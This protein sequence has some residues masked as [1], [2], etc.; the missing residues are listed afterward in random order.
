MNTVHHSTTRSAITKALLIWA[1]FMSALILVW[2]GNSDTQDT[3]NAN[4][5]QQQWTVVSS[6]TD[7][8]TDSDDTPAPTPQEVSPEARGVA[9]AANYDQEDIST[10]ASCIAEANVTMYGTD[11]CPHCQ[12]Q[13]AMFGWSFDS[14]NYVDCDEDKRACGLAWIR[15]YPTWI[16]NDGE[17]YPWTQT[18]ETLSE[19]SGCSIEQSA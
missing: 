18:F 13:K 1:L 8:D 6:N 11:R 12:T 3:N 14:V 10:F 5:V 19:I 7:T 2:C 4:S 9:M 16:D 17:L 15:G